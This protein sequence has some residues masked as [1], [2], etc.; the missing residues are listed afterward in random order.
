MNTVSA[1]PSS[2][3]FCTS[4]TDCRIQVELSC[5]VASV[6]PFASVRFSS[7]IT[8]LTPSATSTVFAP[9][10]LRTSSATARSPFT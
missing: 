4:S 2:S 8:L 3:V 1:A 6:T 5:T 9:E 7:A 10:V